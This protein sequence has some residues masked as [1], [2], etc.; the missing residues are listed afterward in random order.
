MIFISI[1]DKC[2]SL[3]KDLGIS[4]QI[5]LCVVG[6]WLDGISSPFRG[7]WQLFALQRSL[8]SRGRHYLTG[9]LRKRK[10]EKEKE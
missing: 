7:E 4:G 1:F 6:E 10:R 8:T 3:F 9:I 2:L 5:S